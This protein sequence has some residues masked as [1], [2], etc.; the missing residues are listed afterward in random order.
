MRA[1][2]G[3]RATSNGSRTP[4]PGRRRFGALADEPPQSSD[5]IFSANR[6]FDSANCAGERAQADADVRIRIHEASQAALEA[7]TWRYDMSDFMPPSFGHWTPDLQPGSIWQG[8]IDWVDGVNRSTR[9]LLTSTRIGTRSP[10][11]AGR[12]WERCV[13]HERIDGRLS[14]LDSATALAS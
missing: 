14:L 12:P 8:M 2:T 5:A 10:P 6:R 9:Y 1:H 4:E 7:G 11:I 13:I 3:T